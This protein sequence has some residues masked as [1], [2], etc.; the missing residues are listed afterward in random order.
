MHTAIPD[1][2]RSI[3]R[4]VKVFLQTTKACMWNTTEYKRIAIDLHTVNKHYTLTMCVCVCVCLVFIILYT[5][6][7]Y[8]IKMVQQL[9]PYPTA[10]TLSTL[11]V[12][13]RTMFVLLPAS[14]LHYCCCCRHRGCF[15]CCC[16]YKTVNRISHQNIC[17][18]PLS[19]F[20]QISFRT[21]FTCLAVFP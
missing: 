14:V 18:R 6:I 11:F 20:N 17:T 19:R 7:M 12:L 21:I 13:L 1:L 9:S 10:S 15:C 5:I 3:R 4:Y 8:Q 2:S 16:C